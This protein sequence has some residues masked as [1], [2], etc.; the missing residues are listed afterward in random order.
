MN[1]DEALSGEAGNN[2]DR[3]AC[4]VFVPRYFHYFALAQS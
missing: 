2:Q 4:L 3:N 1:G